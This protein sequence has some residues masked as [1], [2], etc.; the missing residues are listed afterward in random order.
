MSP[1]DPPQVSSIHTALTRWMVDLLLQ[2][3]PDQCDEQ[4]PLPVTGPG[5]QALKEASMKQ[6]EE[7][8]RSLAQELL[9]VSK[10]MTRSARAQCA[11]GAGGGV[12]VCCQGDRTGQNALPE[13]RAPLSL[14]PSFSPFLVSSCQDIVELDI[15]KRTMAHDDT[16]NELYELNKLQV[17]PETPPSPHALFNACLRPFIIHVFIIHDYFF[18]D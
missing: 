6:L 18:R 15:Q 5:P 10:Y 7:D 13:N 2:M 11:E 3:V 14:F 4:E 16:D 17:H 9:Y 12:R 8:A 1:S